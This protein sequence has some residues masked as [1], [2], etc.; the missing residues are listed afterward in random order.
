MESFSIAEIT[1]FLIGQ[2]QNQ[3][4]MTGC[5]AIVAPRGA[6]CG[7]DI[8]GGSPGTRDTDALNPLCNRDAVHAVLLSGGSAFGLDAAGGLMKLLERKG[9]GRNVGVTVVPNVC[10]AVLFDLCCGDSSIRPDESMGYQAGENAFA[11]VPFQSGNYGAGTGATIGKICGLDRAMKGGIGTAAFR[12][13]QL[14]A[15]AIFAVNCVGD[16][17]EDGK[18]IAGA[19]KPECNL[20]ADS[21]SVILGEYQ[22]G[23]DFF[24]GNTVIGC[25]MTNALLSKPQASK[26]AGQGQNA[27]A[28]IVHPAHSTFDGDT[29]FA[30][31]SGAVQSSQDAVGILASHAVESAILD[32]VKSARTYGEYLSYADRRRTC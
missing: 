27:I 1:D 22:S 16:I 21:E 17:W 11:R 32:A 30:M 2:A 5:T 23:K 8:R 9:I 10:E 3:T 24:S 15:A 20:F 29:V 26:L 14:Y 6:V 25:I 28:R 4:A 7:I 19:R 12:C 31:C 18:I 13:G